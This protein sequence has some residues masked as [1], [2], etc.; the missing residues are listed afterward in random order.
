MGKSSLLMVLGMSVLVAFCILRLNAN[1]TENVSTTS[2]MFQQTKAR[3]IANSGVE[4][5]LEKL[6]HD[7]T[8]MESEFPG[9][10]LFGGTYD[11]VIEG[12][13][14]CVQVTSIASFM[15]T[16][17][18]TIVEAAVDKLPVNHP[19]GALYLSAAIAANIQPGSSTIKGGITID[20]RNH[21]MDGDLILP[22]EKLVPGIAVDNEE[23]VQAIIDMYNDM[24]EASIIGLGGDPSV[25]AVSESVD[26]AD[27]AQ[28]L[29]DN[30][31]NKFTPET[32]KDT[33]PLWGT[34]EEP[35]VTFIQGDELKIDRYITQ[36]DTVKGCGIL[37][38]DGDLEITSLFQFKG[39]VIAYKDTEINLDLVARGTII[40]GMVACGESV[41]LNAATANFKILH[42][43]DAVELVQQLLET[44]RFE[45]LSWWE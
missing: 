42:S 41:Y 14:D 38:I 16:T 6:K 21:T 45:I 26:W 35:K 18:T 33:G 36:G 39:L 20:G 25:Q 2:N 4:I 22:E 15:G 34:E 30:A 13:E 9:N 31:D 23:N 24:T 29:A 1:S 19:P 3:L 17:H 27:Y 5:Y 40:G 32:I 7:P 8:M 37:I 12:P 11:I 28:L 44:K 10:S 43:Y